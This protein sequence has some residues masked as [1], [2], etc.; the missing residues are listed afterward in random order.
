[1]YA[2][3]HTWARLG[4]HVVRYEDL[5]VDPLSQLQKVTSKVVPLN[6]ERLKTAVLLCNPEYLTRPGLVDPRHLRTRTTGGWIQELP[7]EI[8]DAMAGSPAYASACKMYGYNWT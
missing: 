1:M 3:S 7:S 6:E 4:S 8:V 2:I 5:L